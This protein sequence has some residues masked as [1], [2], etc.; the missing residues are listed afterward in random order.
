MGV[1]VGCS[2]IPICI[3]NVRVLHRLRRSAIAHLLPLRLRL[4]KLP[5]LLQLSLSALV[6]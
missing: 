1:A 2:A 6:P 4:L 5:L 3:V